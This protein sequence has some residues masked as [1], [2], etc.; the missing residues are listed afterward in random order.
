M[1]V[2]QHW[3]DNKHWAGSSSRSTD[4]YNPALG[5]KTASLALA[6]ASDIYHAVQRA[7]HAFPA[8][9]DTPPAKRAAIMF[10]FRELIMKHIDELAQLLSS[11]HGKTIPDAKGEVARGLE[12]V[13]FVCGIP[14]LLKGEFSDQVANAVDSHSLRQPLGVV[15]GITPFN[16]P[17]MVPMWMYPV[18][19]A[20]GN[21]FVLKPSERDPSVPMRLAELFA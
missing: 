18:A 2:I 8:W 16:F 4:V 3:V 13:E 1:K 5:A 12:V 19:I 21:T 14:H 11:E 17:A 9:A 6:S 7:A 15:A 20:C 10:K